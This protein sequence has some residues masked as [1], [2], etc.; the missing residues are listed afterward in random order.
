MKI[1]LLITAFLFFHADF[2]FSAEEL[3]TLHFGVLAYRPKEITLAQWLPLAQELEKNLPGYHVELEPL[4]YPELDKAAKEKQLDF[5]LTNPEHYILLKNII[6]MNAVG[7]MI[8]LEKGHPLTQFSGVI[9]TRADRT[10]IQTLADLNDK[11]IASPGEQSLGGYLMERWELEKN[12]IQAKRYIFTGMPHD[13]VVE[14][15]LS[16]NA[17]VGFVRSGLLEKLERNGK[18]SLG[19]NAT[20]RV[21]ATHPVTDEM[22]VLHSTDHYPEWAFSVR[23]DID[24]EIA[25]RVSLTLLNI[26]SDSDIAKFEGIA[27][28]NS[29]ADYTPVEV[30]MLRLRAHPDELKYF[31][32]ADVMFRYKTNVFI[33]I[34]FAVIIIFFIVVLVTIIRKLRQTKQ[35]LSESHAQISLLLNSMAEGAYGVDNQGFCRFVNQAFLQILGY[36][37][38]E[39][40]IGKYIHELIHHSHADGSFYSSTDCQMYNAYRLHK[41]IHVT[42]EVFWR[43]DGTPVPVEY[44]SQP[45]VANGELT[46]A[47]AT[48]ID[49]T[50][51]QKIQ[52]E[53][54]ESQK[55]LQT[56][57]NSSPECIQ[58]VDAKGNLLDINSAGLDMIELD[59]PEE[60]NSCCILDFIL[61]EYHAKAK[62]LHQRVIAGETLKME[63]EIIGFKGTHRWMETHAVPM[64]YNNEIVRLSMTRDIT[65]R[66]TAEEEIKSSVQYTRS[67]IEASL[68]PLVTISVEGKIT[69]VNVATEKITGL[70]REALIGSDFA[71]YFTDPQKAREGYQK[72]FLDGSVTDYSLAI[73]HISGSTTDVIYNANVYR[74][75]DGE[76]KGL[77]AAARDITER[78]KAEEEIKQLAYFDPLTGLPNRRKLLDRMNDTIKLSHRENK[79]FAVFM[80]D[81]DKFKAV[82]DNLGHAAGDELLKQVAIRIMNRLRESDMVARL[83]GDEFV[84]ILE[85]CAT[86]DDVAKIANNIIADL[87]KPFDLMQGETVFIGASIGISFYPKHGVTPEKLIDNADAA[88]YQA[89]NNG[90]GCFVYF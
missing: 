66:K 49:I 42:N 80:M 16:G 38:A 62:E 24:N 57:I 11:T 64:L 84:M 33:G 83:G 63:F 8:T 2:A 45:I 28:F 88:L 74:N 76:I 55:R 82:N 71:G 77:F 58:I 26:K 1:I 14:E 73:Q 23:K 51:R 30:L 86:T 27:G 10:D 69:D 75:A 29:P 44:W 15:V 53:L 9:F 31:D 89:K 50:E 47:I 68:D 78:K 59:S 67:L 48:F 32:F 25:K 3:K 36:E 17:D 35:H 85:N 12:N 6:G 72:A 19:E 40:I 46:G 65:E 7:T 37:N 22:P 87:T 43:K 54:V 5:V 34:I 70:T 4:N 90:R 39:E 79:V 20:V 81:L 60:M 21:L 13:N 52:R 41:N 56:I 61:P 18:I